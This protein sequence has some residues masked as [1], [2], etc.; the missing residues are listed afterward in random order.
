VLTVTALASRLGPHTSGL[1]ASFPVV[2]AVLS[3]FTHAQRGRDEA[4]RLLR[5]F[6]AG[7][8]SYAV[9][10]LFVAT[11]ARPLGIAPSFLLA[12]AA[13]VVVQ[14]GAVAASRRPGSQTGLTSDC[15]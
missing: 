3:V 7:F 5:G 13:A 9:F 6:S 1:V 14:A 11:T 4:V 2:T 15:A 10:C 8:F 12:T